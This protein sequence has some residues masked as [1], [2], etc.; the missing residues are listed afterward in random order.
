[1]GREV[2]RVPADWGHPYDHARQQLKPLHDGFSEDAKDWDK[3]A[4][5]WERG[6]LEDWQT[7]AAREKHPRFEDYDGPRPVPEDYMPDWPVEKRTH[8]Q[9]YETCSE[10][11]PISP[12]CATPE[13]LARWLADNHASAFASMSA[14]YEQ[15]LGTIRRGWAV[16]AV[17]DAGSKTMTSGVACA[18]AVEQS[19]REGEQERPGD[20]ERRDEKEST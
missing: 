9:M 2:R 12:V 8:W 14:T 17:L 6:E 7:Q 15:W 10:G 4:A 11:T 20:A 16:S 5:A 1:M 19:K 18:Y 3:R 13:E